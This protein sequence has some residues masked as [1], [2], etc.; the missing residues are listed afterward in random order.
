MEEQKVMEG[1]VLSGWWTGRPG[2]DTS[3]W[4]PCRATIVPFVWVIVREG[5]I[6][7]LGNCFVLSSTL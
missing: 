4:S 7:L 5:M 3:H 2:V 1:F 6:T